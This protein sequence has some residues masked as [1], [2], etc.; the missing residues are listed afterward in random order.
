MHRPIQLSIY[1]KECAKTG[2]PEK[3]ARL[4]Q[5]MSQNKIALRQYS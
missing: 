1:S 3:P 5:R 4:L 2:L